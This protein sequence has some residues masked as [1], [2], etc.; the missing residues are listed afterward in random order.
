MELPNSFFNHDAQ[1]GGFYPKAHTGINISEFTNKQNILIEGI[2]GTGKTHIL[3]MIE[4]HC[5]DN[6]TELRILPIFV[7]LAQISEHAR[8][9][10]D[11]FR[12]HLHTHIVQRCLETVE[13]YRKH[14][15]PDQNLLRKTIT[16]IKQLFG[17][18]NE[19]DIGI[20]INKIKDAASYLMFKLQYDLTSE[21]FKQ[22]A[23][24]KKTKSS[25]I[26]PKIN[27]NIPGLSG[28]ISGKITESHSSE[29]ASEEIMMFVGKRLAHQ[30]AAGFIMEFLKQV[31][32]LLD[33]GH[34]LILLDEC[35][36]AAPPAQ[37]EV[38]R[39]F[40]AV[41]GARSLIPEKD[42]LAFFIG[43]VYPH[44]ET[45]YPTRQEYGF[46]F[47]PG[48]DCAMEFLQWD[49]IDKDTYIAFFKDMTLR[50][51]KEIL[52]Y[53]KDFLQLQAEVFDDPSTFLLAIYCANGIPRRYW[54][55]L[56]RG[57]DINSG[58]IL[59]SGVDI[60]VQEI[61]NNQTLTLG[62]LTKEDV[63][64]VDELIDILSN[65]NVEIRYRNRQQRNKTNHIPQN[66]Y[67]SVHRQLVKPLGRLVMQ[68]AIHD[69][70]RMRTKRKRSIQPM[71]SID[72]A[73]AYTFRI[74]P[75]KSFVDT[76]TTD[77]PQGAYS[78]FNQAP[79]I[80]PK[81]MKR[82]YQEVDDIPLD[83][84]IDLPELTGVI[85]SYN[86]PK[87]GVILVDDGDD[88][89]FFYSS[90]VPDHYKYVLQKGDRV[91]FLVEP[92][93]KGEGRRATRIE[94]LQIMLNRNSAEARQEGVVISF[95]EREHGFIDLLDGGPHAVF[96]AN[97]LDESL[98]NKIK[99]GSRVQCS[100]RKNKIGR[101]GYDITL[102]NETNRP[103]QPPTNA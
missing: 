41:R 9:D 17:V 1:A 25:D 81:T 32:V 65:K 14:I 50:R 30:D 8:K 28:E 78:N 2:R 49:E 67:F 69:K 62:N 5:I 12:L 74:I 52:G 56:K 37:V 21:N 20:I 87:G 46:S 35:S 53:E 29:T 103:E 60:A 61:A 7:S 45:T 96:T 36:E 44:G 68:G 66:I 93:D 47:E 3:R 84:D 4:K 72:I 80:R 58:R 76:I 39:L 6:F 64:F 90:Q 73:I 18:K 98:K 71:Y 22:A 42:S 48:H 82:I 63:S 15:Q 11:E 97:D 86:P 33:L 101:L 59:L 88:D 83:S 26:S 43:S 24:T 100:L 102:I 23:N 92:S 99:P 55:I 95:T 34:I 19:S 40:K 89:A 13:T 57:Y 10:P 27:Y 51:A 31:Q 54:Q 91:K 16:S 79:E 85:G 75:P 70:S 94:I 38:F 77:I